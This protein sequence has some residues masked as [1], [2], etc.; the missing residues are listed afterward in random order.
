MATAERI[1]FCANTDTAYEE[2]S[3]HVEKGATYHIVTASFWKGYALP[4]QLSWSGDLDSDPE[5]VL[6]A[7]SYEGIYDGKGHG[8]EINVSVPS[9]G[10]VSKKY[11]S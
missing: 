5:V 11:A 7:S 6:E 3:F 4:M 8:I 10:A 1:A 2:V 9:T